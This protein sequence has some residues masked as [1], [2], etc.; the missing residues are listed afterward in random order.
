M[1]QNEDLAKQAIEYIEKALAKETNEDTKKAMRNTL[2]K[3]K[4][5]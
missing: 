1:E 3:L 2:V 4:E 5:S